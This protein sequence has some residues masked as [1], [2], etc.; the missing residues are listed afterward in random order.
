MEDSKHYISPPEYLKKIPVK[1]YKEYVYDKKDL[2][3]YDEIYYNA[4]K[5][6]LNLQI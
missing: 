6:N 5:D 3:K 1:R 2:D 4:T